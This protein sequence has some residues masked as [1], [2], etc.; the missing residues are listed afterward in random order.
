MAYIHNYNDVFDLSSKWKRFSI[1]THFNLAFYYGYQFL[2]DV[3]V[4]QIFSY[5]LFVDSLQIYNC[6]FVQKS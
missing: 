5:I 6:S 3:K 4:R 1:W 2:H